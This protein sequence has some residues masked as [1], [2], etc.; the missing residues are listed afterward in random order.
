LYL[1][2]KLHPVERSYQG[3]DVAPTIAELHVLSLLYIRSDRNRHY[4]QS[5][6]NKLIAEHDI[7]KEPFTYEG[8]G[9]KR[10]SDLLV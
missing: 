7:S 1:R 10:I 8:F 5:Q 4:N 9:G 2:R 6:S 3:L